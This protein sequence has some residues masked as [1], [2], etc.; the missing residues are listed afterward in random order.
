L[1]AFELLLKH[2]PDKE[3]VPAI[4]DIEPCS[5]DNLFLQVDEDGALEPSIRSDSPHSNCTHVNEISVTASA[6]NILRAYWA[7]KRVR[8]SPRFSDSVSLSATELY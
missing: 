3:F 1:N 7:S 8:F 2:L 6:I 5:T 4:G